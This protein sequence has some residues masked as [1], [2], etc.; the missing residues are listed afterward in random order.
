MNPIR[1]GDINYSSIYGKD[2][3]GVRTE[4]SANQEVPK[5]SCNSKYK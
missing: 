1:F 4:Q 2:G 3:L 5:D